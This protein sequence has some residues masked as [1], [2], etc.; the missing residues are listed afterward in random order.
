MGVEGTSPQCST[1]Y[2]CRHFV[3]E[4]AL[5][6]GPRQATKVHNCRRLCANGRVWP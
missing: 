4:V 3:K 6:K 2:D 1:A 5:E